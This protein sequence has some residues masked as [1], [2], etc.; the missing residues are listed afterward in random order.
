MREKSMFMGPVKSETKKDLLV[1]ASG[2]LTDQTRDAE[3]LWERPAA[4][5]CSV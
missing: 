3:S 2:K 5:Y 1:K 4:N